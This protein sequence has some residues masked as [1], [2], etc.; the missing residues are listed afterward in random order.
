MTL[1]PD[2]LENTY[3]H[4]VRPREEK[5]VCLREIRDGEFAEVRGIIVGGKG[6]EFPVSYKV[7]A[8][9]Q[10]WRIYDVMIDNMSLVNYYRVQFDR[11]PA[12]A[13]FGEL[14]GRI[15]ETRDNDRSKVDLNK[16]LAYLIA[17]R[18]Y[19]GQP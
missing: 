2:L 4:S 16:A 7:H 1:F 8:G 3:V 13:P 6:S 17:A 5:F 11:L 15:Q 18:A 19:R 10:G 12:I 14:V 9:Q